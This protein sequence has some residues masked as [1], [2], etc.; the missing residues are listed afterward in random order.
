MQKHNQ[1]APIVL[2]VYNRLDHTEQTIEALKKNFLAEK[3]ILYIYSDAPKNTEAVESVLKVRKY[4]K[5][6][7]GFKKV[8]IIER[9]TNYGLAASIID[10]VSSICKKYGRVIVLEDDLVTSKCFLTFMNN[11]LEVYKDRSDIF[12][13]TGFSFSQSFMKFPKDYKED[14]YLNIRPMSWS[15][16]TWTDRWS[17]VD[18]EVSDYDVFIKSSKKKKN[19]NRGGPDLTR[20]LKNQMKG[21]LDS[22]YI[23]WT[24]DAYKKSKYT[25]Y[26]RISYVNNIGHDNSGVHCTIDENEIYSHKELNFQNNIQ[27]KKDIQLDSR[28]IENFNKAFQV[29]IMKK[30]KEKFYKLINKK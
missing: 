2:F 11:A 30:I 27:L 12:S 28:I 25:V 20:M 19:F 15:W 14:I 9:E 3:S 17:D 16:A 8:V 21:R 13:I 29:N 10:G 5:S 23:R 6:V 4:I 7:D 22:W 24:Y 26:P 18:W 1:F